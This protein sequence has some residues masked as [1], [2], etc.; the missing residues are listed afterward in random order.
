MKKIVING[1]NYELLKD[2]RDGFNLEEVEGK[3]TDFF[4]NYDYIAGDWAYGKLRLKGFYEEKSKN[5]SKINS[6]KY[7]D[8]YLKNNCACN[9]RY[10]LMKKC[11]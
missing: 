11:D 2:F 5:A 4:E 6:I 8:D 3:L 1:C 10:F 7:F 9:C